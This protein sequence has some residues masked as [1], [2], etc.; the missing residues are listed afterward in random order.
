MDRL[1]PRVVGGTSRSNI[2]EIRAGKRQLRHL[3]RLGFV[4]LGVPGRATLDERPRRGGTIATRDPRRALLQHHQKRERRKPRVGAALGHGRDCA[5]RRMGALGLRRL[6]AAAR[7][8]CAVIELGERRRVA[9]ER[10]GEVLL[11]ALEV[12]RLRR[13][14]AHQP[15]AVVLRAS[16]ASSSGD[17]SAVV[18]IG[19]LRG[20]EQQFG[21]DKSLRVRLRLLH[22]RHEPRRLAPRRKDSR[23]AT[24][25]GPARNVVVDRPRVR[26]LL[27]NERAVAGLANWH[28][29]HAKR[30]AHRST[31]PRNR[32]AHSAVLKH[33]RQRHRLVVVKLA[34]RLHA[35][36]AGIG[37]F[38]GE[39]VR[40]VADLRALLEFGLDVRPRP[41]EIGVA[42]PTANDEAQ[43][44][45]RKIAKAG[46]ERTFGV[47][48]QKVVDARDWIDQAAVGHPLHRLGKDERRGD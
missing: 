1:R 11:H 25:L 14:D 39:H 10:R 22:Q 21:G 42:R 5:R 6:A 44:P 8:S 32:A 29:W 7:R 17:R 28:R 26:L 12:L 2:Q 16:V 37:V 20:A 4:E 30:L 9:R 48:L 35:H 40:A 43:F 23:V 41:H 13:A 46:K 38:V 3:A 19:N 15:R 36:A 47:P 27:P 45:R 31:E 34:A 24:A 18:G 33:D